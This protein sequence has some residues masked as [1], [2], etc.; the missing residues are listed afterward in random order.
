MPLRLNL[1]VEGMA[2]LQRKLRKEVLYAPP[3]REAMESTT[4]DAA[5][6]VEQ[7]APRASGRMAASVTYRV[8]ARPVPTWGRVA[9]TARAKSKKY[10]SGYRYPRLLE[11]AP[12][13]H[14]AGWL[15]SAVQPAQAAL[16]RRLQVAKQRI[17]AI[18]KS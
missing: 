11:F 3:L 13:W 1:R 18:W 6:L 15:H 12:K 2:Q 16:Q 8:D 9:V 10:P 14:H 17:E 4:K 5:Q 7:H